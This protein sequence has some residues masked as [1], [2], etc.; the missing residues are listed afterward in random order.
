[1][2]WNNLRI[3]AAYLGNKAGWLDR[4]YHCMAERN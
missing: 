1:L 3:F 4:R 2:G